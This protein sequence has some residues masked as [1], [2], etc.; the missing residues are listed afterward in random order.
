MVI[1]VYDSSYCLSIVKWISREVRARKAQLIIFE[2]HGF[3]NNSA[4]NVTS[5]TLFR[6][7]HR[8]RLD[9][10]IILSSSVNFSC[11]NELV[12]KF[13]HKVDLPVVSLGVAYDHISSVVVNNT[14]GFE[15][16]V[17]HLLSHGYTKFA[18]IG[19]P[20]SHPES[21]VRLDAFLHILQD[22]SLS[23][24]AEYILEGSFGYMS[25]YNH[26]KNLIDPVKARALDAI[27][28]A[29]DE[30]A[31]GAIRCLTDHDLR[32]PEDVAVTGFD[33]TGLLD[34]CSPLITTV[35]QRFDLIGKKSVSALFEL[36]FSHKNNQVCSIEPELM[37]RESCGCKLT[38]ALKKEA[39]F[40]Y[41][42]SYRMNGRLQLLDPGQL[43]QE[44]TH[45]LE[46]NNIPVCFIVSYPEAM[47]FD[48]KNFNPNVKGSIFYGFLKGKPIQYPKPFPFSD[49]LPDQF[50]EEIQEPVLVKPL[51]FGRS[52][53]GFLLIS[54]YEA[55]APFIDD[56]GLE[57]CHYMGS[58]YQA[59]EQKEIEKRL[60]DAHES[61]KISN[62]RL[63]ELTVKENLDKLT[64]VRYLASNMLQHRKSSTGDYVL[65]LVEI[66]NFNE[67][68]TKYGFTEGEFTISQVSKIL[69][70]SIRD[71]DF[72]SHQNCERYVILVK[73]IQNDPIKTIGSRFIK[74][75]N[76]LNSNV[77]KPYAISFSW[78]SFLG[79]VDQ[80]FDTI[81][82]RAEQNL[83]EYK[84]KKIL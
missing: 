44:L 18:Y 80:D 23:V 55:A 26:V 67:I 72:L 27:V 83:L 51:Y 10:L 38:D 37:I 73:N 42:S 43:H 47:P 74:G 13:A 77:D 81:Y 79:N 50:F 60:N 22:N 9:G 17:L 34:Y 84:Q 71:E 16:I 3:D 62:K 76:E 63:N 8:E 48:D 21:P 53:Y 29:N 32:V 12:Q 68:N 39:P 82:Q 41:I 75:L 65:I 45:Y 58:Q 28:C 5:N 24:P 52:Q 70:N 15:K 11:G 25:G 40:P 36:I 1:G 66:D 14:G 69:A 7:I 64:H 31:L 30:M 4:D 33:G 49:I 19:G 46:E 78:G 20:L 54:A 6:L 57:L 61:L 59:K 56:L 2:G 35:N